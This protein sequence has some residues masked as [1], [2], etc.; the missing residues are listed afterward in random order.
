MRGVAVSDL[1]L[2]AS[3][4]S[5]KRKGGGVG[6]DAW[7]PYYAGFSYHFARQVL[8]ALCVSPRAVILDP[9]N[10]SGTTTAAAL[11]LGYSAV[12]FDLNPATLV[13]ARAKLAV[14]ETVAGL[15]ADAG[16]CLAAARADARDLTMA[17]DADPLDAWLPRR[18]AALTRAAMAWLM[19]RDGVPSASKLQPHSALVALTIMRALREIA[20]DH[21]RSNVTWL[22]PRT[23]VSSEHTD[24]LIHRVMSHAT[25]ICATR[26]LVPER[27]ERKPR[28]ATGDARALPLPG[29]SIDVVLSSPPYCT[30]ID[31][32]KQ[33][34]FELAVVEA[35]EPTRLRTLREQLMGTTTLRGPSTEVSDE[36]PPAV[37]RVLA[38]IAAHPSHRS[39]EYYARNFHQYF[40]DAVRAVKEMARILKR[41]GKAVLVLQ[42]SYYKEIEIAL[43]ELMSAIA[44]QHSLRASIVARRP[45]G[46][47]MTLL[48]TKSRAYKLHRRYTEDVLLLRK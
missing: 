43:T 2:A 24:K 47:H 23:R 42:N 21:T 13:I 12:G 15:C 29:E 5:A 44:E 41:G 46:R 1:T 36:L 9:W 40:V 34:A 11:H 48:N 32:A 19:R 28:V 4:L 27:A 35:S 17:N 26:A 31:Y 30:R 33:T 7:Y 10:G 39:R 20:V 6:V 45:V 16:R 3:A 38:A 37:R 8:S 18:V 14:R 22:Q 25:A